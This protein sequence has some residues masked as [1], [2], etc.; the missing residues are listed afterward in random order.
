MIPRGSKPEPLIAVRQLFDVPKPPRQFALAVLVLAVLLVIAAW[1]GLGSASPGSGSLTAPV[2]IAGHDVSKGGEV[3]VKLSKPIPI[4]VPASVGAKTAKLALDLSGIAIATSDKATLDAAGAGSIDINS[5]KFLVAG[6]VTATLTL[7]G[8]DGSSLGTEKFAIGPSGS[9]FVTIPGVVVILLILFVFAYLE[10]LVRPLW[11]Y[12]RWYVRTGVGL[13]LIG[14]LAGVVA[15]LLAWALGAYQPS[16]VTAI[17]CAVIGAVWAV[18]L[19]LTA[20]R[21]GLRARARRLNKRYSGM[22]AGRR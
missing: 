20:S 22:L 2:T 3:D 12:G 9:G 6:P 13:G 19:G 8:A 17:V 4:S 1:V 18:V 10:S 5:A 21:G 11:R 14:L 15:T 7:Y 16:I